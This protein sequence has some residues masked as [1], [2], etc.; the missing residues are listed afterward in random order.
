[1]KN[2]ASDKKGNIRTCDFISVIREIECANPDMPRLG[3]A[4]RVDQ[5]PVRLSQNI[6][7][8]FQGPAL[9]ALTN[10]KGKHAQRLYCNFLGLLGTNGPMP[11]HYTEYADQR[12]RHH[13]DST[14]KDF[15]DLFNHRFLSLFYRASTQHDP[16]INY[17]RQ[18][19]D[20]ITD[21][22]SA[23]GG[24]FEPGAKDRDAMPDH[25]KRWHGAWMSS[26]CKSPDG[27]TAIIEQHFDLKAKVIEFVGGWLSLPDDALLRLGERRAC[28]VLGKSAYLG[29]RVWSISHKFRLSVGPLSWQDYL[30]F[31]PGQS[32]AKVLHDFVRNYT[33][34]ELDWDVEFVIDKGEVGAFQLNRKQALGF[35]SWLTGSR[36]KQLPLQKV[37]VGRQYI[38]TVNQ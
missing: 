16:A 2:L 25:A 18:D 34:D 8:G 31:K 9:H 29:R 30:S 7:L 20:A 28:A 4:I 22:V 38:S 23:F 5:E 21:I 6:A 33:G 37:V 19:D 35:D 3:H 24:Y 1:M 17:D 14:F 27:L 36:A 13:S 32:R 26:K 15:I 11:L 10:H 12:A